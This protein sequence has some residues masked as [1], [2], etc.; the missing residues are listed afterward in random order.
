V[1]EDE[2]TFFGG[3]YNKNIVR[4]EWMVDSGDRLPKIG[5]PRRFGVAAPVFEEAVVG[6]W[7]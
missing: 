3:C 1:V 2:D 5:G 4:A 7:L 6:A